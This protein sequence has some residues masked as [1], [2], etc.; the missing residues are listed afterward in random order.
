MCYKHTIVH[1]HHT[2]QAAVV[3]FLSI[4]ISRFLSTSEM[5]ETLAYYALTQPI[6]NT[7][8]TADGKRWCRFLIEDDLLSFALRAQ[9]WDLNRNGEEFTQLT[10]LIAINTPL[11]KIIHSRELL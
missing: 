7:P 1:L 5:G 11:T 10:A 2:H 3:D 6:M 4:N 8:P 9:S